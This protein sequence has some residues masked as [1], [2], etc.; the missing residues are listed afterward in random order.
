[1]PDTQYTEHIIATVNTDQL[2][3]ELHA[4]FDGKG[5]ELVNSSPT[6]IVW[7]WYNAPSEALDAIKAKAGCKGIVQI[8]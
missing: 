6:S 2:R 1:M 4:A 8:S 7:R 5:L 3:A